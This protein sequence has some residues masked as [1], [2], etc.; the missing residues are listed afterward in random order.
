MFSP[1]C[2]ASS[3]RA[4]TKGSKSPEGREKAGKRNHRFSEV[5]RA[6]PWTSILDEISRSSSM[7]VIL[8]GW[9][10]IVRYRVSCCYM[11]DAREK[12]SLAGPPLVEPADLRS[13][14]IL[15]DEHLL[16]FDK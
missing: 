11:I 7:G 6:D 2:M 13:W 4:T 8:G 5:L 12:L 9:M 16:V 15:E 1:F 3:R 10:I 14:L